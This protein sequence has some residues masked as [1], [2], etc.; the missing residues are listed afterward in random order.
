MSGDKDVKRDKEKIRNLLK[1]VA[2]F[3]QLSEDDLTNVVAGTTEQH[4]RRGETIFNRG[5]ACNGF[6]IVVYGQ[7]KLIAVSP[8][9]AEKVVRL[10]GPGE[11]FGEAL[12]FLGKPY[13]LSAIALADSMLLNVDKAALFQELAVRPELAHKIIAGLS[14][15]LHSFVADV[16]S[17]SLHSGTQRV[18]GYLLQAQSAQGEDT[19]QLEV[20]K[21]VIASRLNLTPEHFSRILHDLSTKGLIQVERRS[22]TI[23]DSEAFRTYEA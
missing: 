2:L 16:Q 1:R 23:L 13:I 19:I 17:Y 6:H 14:Q 18:I 8:A 21:N 11:T 7:V 20:G 9:G 10:L 4:I 5:D 22:I 15:R 3:D 12:M